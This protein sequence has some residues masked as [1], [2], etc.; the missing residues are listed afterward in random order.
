MGRGGGLLLLAVALLLVVRPLE[1]QV[2]LNEVLYDPEGADTGYE[3]VEVLNCGR[4]PVSLAGWVLETGNGASPDDWTVEWVGGDLDELGSGE[5]LLIG[6][7]AVVPPPDVV[8]PLDLQNGPDAARLRDGDAVVDVVGWGEPLFAGYCEGSPAVD[9]PG[10]C[11][12]ARSPD[13]F[14][15]DDNSLDFVQCRT[16]TPGARNAAEF[17]LALAVR[18]P[19]RAVFPAAGPVR[20]ECVVRNAGSV[21]NEGHAAT[22]ELVV[23]GAAAPVASASSDSVL[24]PRDSVALALS[25]PAPASG[26]HRAVL[27]LDPGGDEDPSDNA[28]ET[29]FTVGGPGGLLV[30]NEIMYSPADSATEWVEFVNA[31]D[32]D[33][34]VAGWLLG[35]DRDA[36]EIEADSLLVVPPGGFLVV[37]ADTA[38]LPGVPAP[39]TEADDW[40]ALSADDTVVLLDRYETV[41]DRVTYDDRWGGGRGVSLERVRPDMPADDAGNWGSSVSPEGG[42]PGRTNSIHIASFPSR[43]RLTVE[44]NPFSPDGDGRDDRTAVALDLPVAQAVARV[45]VYDAL[46]RARAV[47]LD[48]EHVASRHELLWDGTGLDGSPLPSGLYVVCLE[49]LNAREGVLVT[50]K[51]AVGIVR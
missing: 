14:D 22:V 33:V 20:I 19:G 21:P 12:L 45:T 1:A 39:F 23:D 24:A 31:T 15:H 2:V 32:G 41:I 35:D 5:F 36:S 7:D 38:L 50:A 17:D 13:C 34:G 11:S 10:G 16:P 48:H 3:F 43:G 4:L 30:V 40:E 26:Y 46:G 6:E 44:P 51:C 25:W 42:T 29:S 28:C 27:R 18:H 37:A 47:L 9:V 49:A 8:T